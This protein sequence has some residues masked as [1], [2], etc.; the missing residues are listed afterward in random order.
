MRRTALRVLRRLAAVPLVAAVGLLLAA[1]PQ[2]NTAGADTTHAVWTPSPADDYVNYVA[3]RDDLPPDP[4]AVDNPLAR[5]SA[6]RA[7]D[8]DR[9]FAA[10]NPVAARGLAAAERTAAARGLSPKALAEERDRRAGRP[11]DQPH[12]ARLLTILVEFNDHADDDFS[13]FRRPTSVLD[14]TCVTE[15]P[16]TRMNGPRHNRLP[17]PAK[18]KAG[19]NNTL[20]VPDFSPA[21]YNAMLYSERGLAERVRPDLT[22]PDGRP[23]VD[24]SGLTMRAMYS[25]MSHGAYSVGGEAVGWVTV[26]HSEAWYAAGKCGAAR[27]DN[28]G[29]ADNPRGVR[30]FVIDAVD[31]LARTHPDFPW[32]DYDQED[33]GDA[34]HDGNLHEPDGVVDHLVLVHA[35]RD[36]SAGGGAEGPYAIW[37]H[38]SNVLGGHQVPGSPL[39]VANYIVQP[40]DSGVG[41][42]AHEFGHDLGLP[43]LYDNFSGGETDVDFWDLMSS[44]SHSGPLFQS[45]PA[46]MGA[47]SKYMLGWTDPKLF[48]VGDER[49]MVSV[50]SAARPM[51]GM[52]DS[53]RVELPP[54]TVRIGTP[55]SGTGMWY[56][57]SDQEW[58]DTSVVRDVTVPVGAAHADLWMWNDYVIEQDWDYGFVE[59]SGDGGRTWSQLPVRDEAGD[60]VSTPSNYPDPNRNLAEFRKTNGLTGSSG[61]WRHDRVDLT[62]Y[63]GRTVQ[64][65]LGMMTDAAFM[66]R[67][68]FA[69]DFALVADGATVWSDDVE[70]GDNGWRAVTGTSTI[71][72]GAGWSRT[73]GSFEREQYYLLEWRTP[74]GFDEGLKYAYTTV[75]GSTDG[76]GTQVARVPY[77]VPGL[78]VWL[79]DAEYQNNGVRFNLDAPPSHGPKGQVLLVD[80]HVDPLRWSGEAGAHY[81][82]SGRNPFRN[83]ENR[84]QSSNA[85]FGAAP[86]LPFRACHSQGAWCQE[87]PALP[88]VPEFTDARGWAAG[89]QY[90]DGRPVD[91]FK[92]GG[93]VVPA[94]EPYPTR[95]VT[96]DGAPDTAHYGVPW[97]G[98]VL[99]SGDPAP[100]RE[101]GVVVRVVRPYGKDGR[102]GA[103]VEVTPAR[104]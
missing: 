13:G 33:L 48:R 103:L 32:A 23:G 85:A 7:Q 96:A 54:E 74:T 60:L 87:F 39:K 18:A 69:D 21:H 45:M 81:P 10:G 99:G 77:N 43:D 95:V 100:G 24:M 63:A 79:R 41:V 22:G 94:R 80:A 6:R 53:V 2:Q 92:D 47:W 35:G 52:R 61:G 64:V 78:L 84:A 62:P 36:K 88:G 40:E 70:H 90:L 71:T 44:G 34:D 42:F 75:R 17:D 29:S 46:H 97:G 66:E 72:R 5:S 73:T 3:P 37:A 4:Q 98:S 38:A 58:A 57:G 65:R 27:Q 67:G 26:P 93:T 50:G 16:G 51:P 30:Q 14:P 86:T 91:R 25:E 28:S 31:E 9:K 49:A 55:H 104:R 76:D 83:L 59:V 1:A 82:P 8:L 56:S 15:P 20:W 68:W 101:Y 102:D 12:E 19:D 11:V 89:A